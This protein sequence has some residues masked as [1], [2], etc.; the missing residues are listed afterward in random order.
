M[1]NRLKIKQIDFSAVQENTDGTRF[2][3]IDENGVVSYNT[4]GASYSNNN[5]VP[6]AIGG[7]QSGQTFNN[8]SM[9]EMWD[10][11][12]YPYQNPGFTTFTISPSIGVSPTNEVGQALPNTLIFVWNS[13]N[14]NNVIE[15]S[16]RISDLY[17]VPMISDQNYSSAI[18]S[19][20]SYTYDTPVSRNTYGTYSWVILGINTNNIQ[21]NKTLTYSWYWRIY[22]GTSSN[23]DAPTES[24]IEGLQN[25][26]LYGNRQRTYTFGEND[27]KY[28]AIPTAYGVPTSVLYQGLP[29]ALA[30]ESDGYL[31][32]SG[33]ITYTQLNITNTYGITTTYNIFRSK[34]P[35]VSTTS[36]VVS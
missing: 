30:D 7:I 28:L 1:D 5:A 19:I 20:T 24:L 17:H 36:M 16:V 15:N 35:I 10:M 11:L 2:L 12:L 32:G 34:N 6:T 18:S 14:S 4:N 23:S 31:L 26:Q 22:W 33:N 8:K 3:V 27:Y 13:S 29:Y 21:Y 9:Q 25:S